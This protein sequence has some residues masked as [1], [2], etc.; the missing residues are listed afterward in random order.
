MGEDLTKALEPPCTGGDLGDF[1]IP[2]LF[3]SV[4]GT[5]EMSGF[6]D[7]DGVSTELLG[8]DAADRG[9]VGVFNEETED[10]VLTLGEDRG[11]EP[12]LIRARLA[13]I[14]VS[15]S[16]LEPGS[17]GVWVTGYSLLE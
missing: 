6:A 2:A 12:K 8:T 1:R 16:R 11:E 10:G 7:S 14:R 13:P 17:G 4:F 9:E 3:I 5:F 15:E